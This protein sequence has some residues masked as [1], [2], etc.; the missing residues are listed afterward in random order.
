MGH[1]SFWTHKGKP[2]PCRA[3]YRK[4]LSL[5]FK[6]LTSAPRQRTSSLERGGERRVE[7]D[8]QLVELAQL[9]E[10]FKAA[11]VR[12]DFSTCDNLLSQL[13]V[14]CALLPAFHDF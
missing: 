3:C 9:F 5:A 8:P 14:R 2:V 12:N 11:C 7:M 13:K 10:R 4:S 1:E 6:T